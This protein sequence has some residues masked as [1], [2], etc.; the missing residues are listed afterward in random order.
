MASSETA[1]SSADSPLLPPSAVRPVAT[2]PFT[3]SA[4]R[5]QG[6]PPGTVGVGVGLEAIA[7]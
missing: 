4:H 2:Q 5:S 7:E 3:W 1:A 6:C